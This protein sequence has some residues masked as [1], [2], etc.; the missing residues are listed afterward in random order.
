MAD[1]S[2]T[3]RRSPN[4]LLRVIAGERIIVP[5]SGHLAQMDHVF[6][7]NEVGQFVWD[8]LDGESTIGDIAQAMVAEYDVG[9][10][11]AAVDAAS[12]VNALED[13]DLVEGMQR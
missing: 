7:L 11:D 12:F 13:H 1:L 9:E 10:G 2:D 8:R 4:A 3:P 5:I 6:A